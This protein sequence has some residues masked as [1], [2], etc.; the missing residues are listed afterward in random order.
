MVSIARRG[1]SGDWGI[2]DPEKTLDRLVTGIGRARE[3]I[4]ES[5]PLD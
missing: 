3:A 4:P 1:G 5:E 2:R